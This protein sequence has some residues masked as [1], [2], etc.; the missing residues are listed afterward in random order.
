MGVK[1]RDQQFFDINQILQIVKWR[2]PAEPGH[3]RQNDPE[4]VKVISRQALSQEDEE[5]KIHIL[6]LIK[7]V[8]IPTAS[9]ILAVAYPDRYP[10][11]N[12]MGWRVLHRWHYLDGNYSVTHQAWMKYL[13]ACEVLMKKFD[14]SGQSLD[15]VLIAVYLKHEE[16]LNLQKF[17]PLDQFF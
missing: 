15:Q 5:I 7:G 13:Q 12:R 3:L 14:L 1:I 10:T 11:L 16:K 17:I 6:T 8:A 4:R 2:T 9:K